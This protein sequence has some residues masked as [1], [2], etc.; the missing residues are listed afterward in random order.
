MAEEI[1]KKND[2]FLPLVIIICSI[3]IP[4]SQGALMGTMDATLGFWGAFLSALAVAASS[5]V[6][7]LV[8]KPA[9][10]RRR[11][12]DALSIT[13][14]VIS[15]LVGIG[16]FLFWGF[17][18]Q[19]NFTNITLALFVLNGVIWVTV[20]IARGLEAPVLPVMILGAVFGA[21]S[22]TGARALLSGTAVD[23]SGNLIIFALIGAFLGSLG[24]SLARA[25]ISEQAETRGLDTGEP[26]VPPP[27]F[28]S[29]SGG[30]KTSAT[31][32]NGGSDS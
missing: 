29:E 1:S 15:T 24:A 28:D 25:S 18:I 8:L 27:S 26:P 21:F 22:Y 16:A 30:L 20:M 23:M 6:S 14:G 10:P 9:F 5:L 4:I 19:G 31:S 32:G 17:M 3:Y 2:R 11:V 7:Y 13:L 12:R